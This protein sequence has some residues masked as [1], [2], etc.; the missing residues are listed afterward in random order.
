MPRNTTGGNKHKKGKNAPTKMLREL[1]ISDNENTFYGVVTAP[2]GGTHFAVHCNDSEDR[3]A[4]AG[5]S[6]YRSTR[7]VRGD[8]LLVSL[9]D[10]EK[11]KPGSKQHCDIVLKYNSNE[12]SQLRRQGVY[13]KN[14]SNVFQL[15]IES[16]NSF[17]ESKNDTIQFDSKLTNIQITD[18]LKEKEDDEAEEA[19]EDETEDSDDG[20]GPRAI[21]QQTVKDINDISDY[22]DEEEA[23]ENE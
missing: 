2:L 14:T 22:E 12:I 11:V 8:L 6:I 5:G 3:I 7:I 16:D 13:Y 18:S 17:K 9:R 23:V 4:T 21:S 10:F 20:Y 19:E 1:S 15:S